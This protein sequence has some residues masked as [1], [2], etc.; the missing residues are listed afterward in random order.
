LSLEANQQ[1]FT[2]KKNYRALSELEEV[3]ADL[4]VSISKKTNE[5]RNRNIELKKKTK[6]SA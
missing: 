3:I 1:P 6:G 2:Q 4:N 5:L